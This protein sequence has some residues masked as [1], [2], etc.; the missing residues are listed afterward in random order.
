MAMG[1]VLSL[2]QTLVFGLRVWHWD[3]VA[4]VPACPSSPENTRAIRLW[5]LPTLPREEHCAGERT[6]EHT[7]G[8]VTST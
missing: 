5:P 8:W 1:A 2:S 7:G 3:V 6:R 4:L